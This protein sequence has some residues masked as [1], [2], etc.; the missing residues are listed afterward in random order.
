MRLNSLVRN[1]TTSKLLRCGNLLL[2]VLRISQMKTS[3]KCLFIYRCTARVY[4]DKSHVKLSNMAVVL[5][6]TAFRM[7]KGINSRSQWPCGL[8][9]RSLAARLLR[10]WVRIPPGAWIFVSCECC[11][12]SGREVSATDLSFVQRSPTECG[13]SLCVIKKPRKRGG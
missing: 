6:Q 12:L 3:L 13:A 10:L 7:H 2:E 1:F 5:R 11:V 8:R 4:F 9:R